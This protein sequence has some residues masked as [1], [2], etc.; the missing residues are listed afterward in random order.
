MPV[1]SAPRPLRI[2]QVV[3]DLR[4]GGAERFALWLATALRDAGHEVH[5][6]CIR[7]AGPL[8]AALDADMA[9]RVW[10]AGKRAHFDATVLRRLVRT[11]RAL[12]PDV[13]H[14]HLFTAL[15]WGVVAARAAGVPVVVHTQHALHDDDHLEAALARPWLAR[16]LDAV[17]AVH[18]AVAD[19]LARRGWVGRTPI[20]VFDNALPLAGR[21]RARLGHH[22]PRLIAVGRLVALKGHADLIDAM[23]IITDRGQE[24]HLSILGDG[25]ERGPLQ[26]RIQALGL[27]D[28][29]ALVGEVDDVPARL[30][31]ADLFVH[32][33]HHE[34]MPL[35]V[36][37]AAAAGLPLVLTDVGGAAAILRHG[38][39]G[40]VVPPRDPVALA[41]AILDHLRLDPGAQRALGAASRRTARARHDLG[42][43]AE[44]HATLYRQ[45]LG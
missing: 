21:P 8:A 12:R 45:L 11:L 7:D 4:V 18:E 19:D 42:V 2:V 1:T 17:L 38:A 26:R 30:A 5:L 10:T 37:E 16:G 39:G 34:A 20:H 33:S 40:R 35:A 31:R 3:P 9:S 41:D 24:L 29:V 14:T 22:P 13:V 15:S 43:C 27:E 28:R 36:L 25:P 6:L 32:P 23:R 44:H